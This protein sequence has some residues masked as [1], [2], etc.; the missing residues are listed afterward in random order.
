MNKYVYIMVLQGM[1]VDNKWDDI[2]WEYD[3]TDGLKE[4]HSQLKTYRENEM[5][6]AHR[7]IRRRVLTEEFNQGRW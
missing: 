2:L 7:V 3:N 1:Y 6:I 4:M 5:G